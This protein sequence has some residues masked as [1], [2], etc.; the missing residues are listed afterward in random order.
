MQG[1]RL[2][3]VGVLLVAAAAAAHHAPAIFDQ[4]KTVVIDG[5]VTEFVWQNPHSWIRMDVVE[6]NG[7]T[8]N[9]S[10]EMNPPTYLVR[11]GWKS[12][13]LTPGD[14]ISVVANPLRTGDE[15]AAKFVAVTL[16]DGRVLGEVEAVLGVREE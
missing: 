8:R 13:T 9:W 7:R 12:T 6:A 4:T 2:A 16:P 10:I 15:P 11:G 3:L 5:T 1:I 14:R